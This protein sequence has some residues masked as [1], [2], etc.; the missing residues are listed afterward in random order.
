LVGYFAVAPY[1]RRRPH[2]PLVKTWAWAILACGLICAVNGGIGTITGLTN[3][4]RAAHSVTV[5]SPVYA[6][7]EGSFEVL[8]NVAFGFMFSWLAV[9]G[10]A[11][12]RLVAS[13]EKKG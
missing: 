13:R 5:E 3:V 11:T 4:Y 10:F 7:A 8:F 2:A 6:L 12:M 1:A 9:F